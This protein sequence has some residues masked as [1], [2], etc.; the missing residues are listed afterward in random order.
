MSSELSTDVQFTTGATDASAC[1]QITVVSGPDAGRSIRVDESTPD[2]ALVG[3]SAAADLPLGDRL[4]SRRH[5]AMEV[6]GHD[7]RLEDLGSTN[8]TYVG[9]LRIVQV[10]LR[11]GEQIT[12]GRTTLEITRLAA[13][14]QTVVPAARGFGRVLGASLVM[15]RIYPVLA[16]LAQSD[17]SFLLEGETG[18]GKELV[19]ETLHEQ[20]ARSNGP[21]VVF[22]CAGVVEE[23]GAA[24]LL[25]DA[26]SDGQPR[27]V[28]EMAHGGTLVLDEIGELPIALQPLLLRAIERGEV[29]RLGEDQPRKVS[30][31]IIATTRLDL[32]RSIQE[33]TFRDDLFHRLATTRLELPPLRERAGDVGLLARHFWVHLGGDPAAMPYDALETL[34]RASFPG[35]V[36]ELIAHVTRLTLGMTTSEP[37]PSEAGAT[38]RAFCHKD[39]PYARA[40]EH[41][42]AAFERQYVELMVQEHGTVQRAAAA[43]GLALRYFQ[44]LRARHHRHPGGDGEA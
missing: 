42:L 24:Q 43:S 9:G 3:Q 39:M 27:G 34:E 21:F 10:L 36:R 13:T 31:R 28:F 25:G 32:D 18:T 11:G 16:R 22:D 2:R 14:A 35:N 12:L 26:R 4:V 44:L 15:R 37:P 30:V 29:Q 41:L 17:A 7:L 38:L 20:G 40:K 6:K 33:G 1:F 8:G 19:A 5:L 23:L